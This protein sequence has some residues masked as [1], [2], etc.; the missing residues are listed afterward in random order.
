MHVLKIRLGF[1]F[2]NVLYFC[3]DK[4]LK[5][6]SIIHVIGLQPF[7]IIQIILFPSKRLNIH[8]PFKW[9]LCFSI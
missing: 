3:V 5:T 2:K 7:N 6:L 1:D 4:C 9:F 8:D